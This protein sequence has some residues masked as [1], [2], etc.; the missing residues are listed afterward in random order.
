[1]CSILDGLVICLWLFFMLH[2]PLFGLLEN[3]LHTLLVRQPW[4]KP[5]HWNGRGIVSGSKC[6]HRK[7]G[8]FLH[9]HAFPSTM[10]VVLAVSL[11]LLSARLLYLERS[12]PLFRKTFTVWRRLLRVASSNR[13]ELFGMYDSDWQI[14]LLK[15]SHWQPHKRG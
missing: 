1:M 15:L 12:R 8:H 5:P 10:C 2:L 3:S 7:R 14:S 11:L 13:D 6:W 4:R 9:S